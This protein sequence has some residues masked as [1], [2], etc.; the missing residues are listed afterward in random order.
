MNLYSLQNKD[1]NRDNYD[2]I[3]YQKTSTYYK[4][5]L[6]HGSNKNNSNIK[7]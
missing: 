2:S 3:P 4:M 5:K 6:N 1:S 7:E